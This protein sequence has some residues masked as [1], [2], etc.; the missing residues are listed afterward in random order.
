MEDFGNSGHG[1]DG[2]GHREDRAVQSTHMIGRFGHSCQLIDKHGHK[3]MTR[4]NCATSPYPKGRA[5]E[6]AL[7][8]QL[9]S[10]PGASRRTENWADGHA[11][12][13]P[14]DGL[15][16]PAGN[17]PPRLGA[18]HSLGVHARLLWSEQNLIPDARQVNDHVH[19][20]VDEVRYPQAL[21]NGRLVGPLAAEMERLFVETKHIEQSM[22]R[23]PEP[24]FLLRPRTTL[25]YNANSLSEPFAAKTGQRV[26]SASNGR[27]LKKTLREERGV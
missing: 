18:H 21:A 12:R 15:E 5:F 10:A 17:V 9:K 2:F 14:D 7:R 22:M 1:D 20:I 13:A 23:E 19:P 26:E 4:L 16:Q 27:R 24:G 8:V 11:K 25:R 3:S 6:R